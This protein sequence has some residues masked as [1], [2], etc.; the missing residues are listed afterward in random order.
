M[1][2]QYLIRLRSKHH[3]F[4]ALKKSRL[5][6]RFVLPVLDIALDVRLR[7]MDWPVRVR[8]MRHLSYV[9]DSR[10]VESGVSSLFL[11]LLRCCGPRV[12]WDVGVNFGYYSWLFLS[13][14]E[15]NS[16]LL[17]E[18]DSAN[19]RLIDATIRRNRLDRAR[20]AAAAVSDTEGE[21][22]FVLDEVSGATG[23]LAGD[24]PT[25]VDRHYGRAQ[26][27]VTVGAVTLDGEAAD[28]TARHLIKIDVEGAEEA[29]LRGGAELVGTRQ[30][31]ILFESFGGANAGAGAAL[32]DWGYR[33]V[34]SERPAAAKGSNFLALPPRFEPQWGD[35]L[36]RWT[37]MYASWTE[38]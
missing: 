7:D 11:A 35:I 36:A 34:G 38:R 1:L 6:S 24:E 28:R 27:T 13:A 19:L 18:P 26:R 12:F 9:A 10:I 2:T 17:Y 23:A 5:F 21:T 3:P 33:V 30:P 4:H 22:A 15:R 29:V 37:S 14:D 8:L 25:F 16:A 31:I 20:A 32:A